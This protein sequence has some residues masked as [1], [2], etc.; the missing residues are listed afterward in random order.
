L[1]V[2]DPQLRTQKPQEMRVRFARSLTFYLPLTLVTVVLVGVSSFGYSWRSTLVELVCS[3]QDD[4]FYY[5]IPAW[6]G[7]HGAGLTFGGEK[8]SGFQPLYEVLLTLLSHCCSSIE[9]LIRLSIN[10]NGFLFAL[11]AALVGLATRPL[12]SGAFPQ[13]RSYAVGSGMS[14]SALT[15]LSLHTVFF[16]SLTGK[17][18][19]LAAFLLA[20]IIWM[21]LAC[22]RGVIGSI[23]LGLLCG[24]LILTRIAPA[25]IAYVAIAIAFQDNVRNRVAAAIACGLPLSLWTFFAHRYF[26]H[27]LPMSML[28]KAAAPSQLSFLQSIKIGIKYSLES[29]RFS[30]SAASRFNV[31]QLQARE[32]LRPAFEIWIMVLALGG[33]FFGLLTRI[34]T[35]QIS[36]PVLTLLLFD[37][38]GMACN[39]L[40]G[41]LQAGRSDD[42]YYSVW[43]IYDLPVLIA[44]NCGFAIAWAQSKLMNARIGMGPVGL[45]LTLVAGCAAY[46]Y[47]DVAWYIE[48]K[49]YT[50]ADDVEFH[51]T[52]QFKKFEVAEWFL[53]HVAPTHGSYKV[54]SFS[55]GAMSYYLFDHVVNLDG[56]AND[57]AGESILS[58]HSVIPY[59]QSIRPDYL[60]DNCGAEQLFPNLQRV[61]LISFPKQRDYCIDRFVYDHVRQ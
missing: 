21:V 51:P 11:T 1:G 43:Y 34:F 37:A 48:L 45:T 31:L 39:L 47:G 35:Q 20:G 59:A 27:V 33:A 61:H 26:G 19:A 49:P 40:F 52:S 2:S 56:L 12:I 44:I 30:L 10:L 22:R 32:G 53:T 60:I 29:I 24:L 17:E 54:V 16:S 9:S 13:L 36:R 15:F 41:I 23:V 14:V 50:A 4:S 18:N 42:I 55:A 5:F 25:S 58:K 46:F 28:V 3:I 57:A 6:N 7:G 8:T 38:S